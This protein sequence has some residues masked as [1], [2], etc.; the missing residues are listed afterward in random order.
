L[1]HGR[2]FILVFLSLGI[3]FAQ[4]PKTQLEKQ[5]NALLDEA[6]SLDDLEEFQDEWLDQIDESMLEK[7]LPHSQIPVL[8]V[9]LRLWTP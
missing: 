1:S 4:T 5:V 9:K 7:K 2:L 3:C 8:F 6:D